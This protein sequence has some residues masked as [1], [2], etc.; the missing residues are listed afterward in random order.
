MTEDDGLYDEMHHLQ[1]RPDRFR[2][3]PLALDEGTAERLLAGRLDPADA[4]PAYRRAAKVLAAAAAPPHPQELAGEAWAVAQLAAV[5]GSTPHRAVR[6]RP[7]VLAKVLS[8]KVATAAAIATLF[9]ASVAGAATGTLPP[10]AQRVAHRML[11]SAGVPSPDDHAT[12]QAPTGH[13][14]S[15]PTIPQGTTADGATGPNATGSAKDGLCRA[16]QAGQGDQRGGKMDATAFQALA[17]AAGGAEKIP[18]YCDDTT[19][20]SGGHDKAAPPTTTSQQSRG[21]DPD[22]GSGNG[23]EQGPG[24]PPSTEHAPHD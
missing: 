15:S 19:S 4:P 13:A 20:G 1:P 18:A 12:P 2:S 3:D 6:R 16:W 11:G 9:L 8:V 10:L 7:T 22:Q 24:S 14:T 21:H 5:A 23:Q 17:A